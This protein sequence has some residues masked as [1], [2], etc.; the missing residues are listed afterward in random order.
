MV[1]D[2][3]EMVSWGFELVLDNKKELICWV[4]FSLFSW[5][6]KTLIEEKFREWEKNWAFKIILYPQF[7]VGSTQNIEL[8][9]DMQSIEKLRR[10]VELPEN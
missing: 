10:L 4:L 7:S 2:E 1:E 8:F 9:A 5:V 3:T 6:F